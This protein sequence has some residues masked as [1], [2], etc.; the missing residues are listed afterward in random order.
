MIVKLDSELVV[1][2][3]NIVYAIK[4]LELLRLFLRVCLLEQEFDYIEY[5]H[6]PKNLNTLVDAIASSVINKNLR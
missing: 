6:I 3:L 4:N 2:H 1:L 5:Q